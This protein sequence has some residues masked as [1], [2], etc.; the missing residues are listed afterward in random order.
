MI[1]YHDKNYLLKK[2]NLGS[3]LLQIKI[4]VILIFIKKK[5]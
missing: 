1:V 3:V 2:N 5:S 4:K